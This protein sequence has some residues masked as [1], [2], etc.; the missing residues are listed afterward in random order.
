MATLTL[1]M[2]AVAATA[3]LSGTGPAS[4]ATSLRVGV[5]GDLTWGISRSDMD[6]TV[7]AMQSA[8]VRWARTNVS[9][10]GAEPTA[11]GAFNSGWLADIDYGV[12][13]LRQAGISVL[14][15]LAD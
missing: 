4:A 14:M 2:A 15:P 3:G 1:V 8:G 9:W 11:K 7:A 12:N 10:S 6:R 13:A 5:V